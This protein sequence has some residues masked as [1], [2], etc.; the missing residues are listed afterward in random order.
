M[1]ELYSVW[2]PVVVTRAEGSDGALSS[3]LRTLGIKVLLWPAVS[4][5]AATGTSLSQALAR[6]QD[7]DWIVF[8]S[9]N[10]VAAV[11]GLL[12]QLPSGLRVAAIG[13]ATAQVLRHRGVR[14]GRSSRSIAERLRKI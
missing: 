10:A 14:V 7:F 5:A 1:S 6:V 13:Q 2:A 11:L 9:R 4:V 3:Q 8:A 12:P